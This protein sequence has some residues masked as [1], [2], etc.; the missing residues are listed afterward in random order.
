MKKDDFFFALPRYT[1]H[2][3]DFP[4]EPPLHTVDPSTMRKRRQKP[5]LLLLDE[6]SE[7]S[8]VHDQAIEAE[9]KAVVTLARNA[10]AKM[11]T[12]AAEDWLKTEDGRAGS[13]AGTRV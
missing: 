8:R 9:K 1:V 4:G 11:E 10:R 2:A 6:A 7:A 3:A 13:S 5:P 12:E